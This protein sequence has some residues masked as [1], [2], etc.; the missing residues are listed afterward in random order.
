MMLARLYVS[1]YVSFAVS[2]VVG[3]GY[4]LVGDREMWSKMFLSSEP[5]LVWSEGL[6]WPEGP[7]WTSRGLMFSDTITGRMY[8]WDEA[9]L[10][11]KVIKESAGGCP[12]LPP[13]VDE[14]YECMEDAA[15][16]GANGMSKERTYVKNAKPS[17]RVTVCQHGAR[18]LASMDTASLEMTP[19][20][21][22]YMGKK[23]NGPNDVIN[24]GETGTVIFTDPYYG[25]LEKS[26]FYDDAYTDAKSDLGF[27]GVYRFNPRS[28][29]MFLLDA[30]SERPNG[31]ATFDHHRKL[32]VSECCQGHSDTCPKGSARWRLFDLVR[33]QTGAELYQTIEH[34]DHVKTGCAD[35]F[36]Y[37]AWHHALVA[38]CPQGL[39]VVDIDAG[40][41][42]AK[43]HFGVAV[44]NVELGGGYA[45]I[46]GAKSLWRIKLADKPKAL[47]DKETYDPNKPK[48]VEWQRL[49]A[50]TGPLNPRIG[51]SYP[52]GYSEA[53]PKADL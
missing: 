31:L 11:P 10:S 53:T 28:G 6:E 38:S 50:R 12:K 41:V 39:C 42:V 13:V 45:W 49:G 34:S 19:L 30:T 17:K 2:G 25:F 7:T 32:A 24:L 3:R 44:S 23:L 4:E 51:D 16:P 36:K 15:E 46:T 52:M 21:S 9:T 26:R 40:A 18:R 35:G 33:G 37:H 1:C 5:E 27:A 22:E 43:L 14:T 48:D 47:K 29:E 8:L 20:V